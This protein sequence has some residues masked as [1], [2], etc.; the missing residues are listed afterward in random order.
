MA[1][2]TIK[3]PMDYPGGRFTLE[4]ARAAVRALQRE[5]AKKAAVKKAVSQKKPRAEKQP[6]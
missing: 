2:R 3:V 5:S 4:E 6:E 1:M